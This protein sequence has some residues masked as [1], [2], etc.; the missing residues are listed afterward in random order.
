VTAS[1]ALG[2][3]GVVTRHF[4]P[5]LNAWIDGRRDPRRPDL[6]TYTMRHLLWSGL[7][8]LLG[9]IGSR[10]Q[11]T[12]ETA[13][14][15][16]LE[17][18]LGLSGSAEEEAAHPGTLNHL[19]IH[20]HPDELLELNAQL[21][22]RLF[23][24]RCLEP[25]RFEN[26][27]VVAVD[28]VE[29]RTYAEQHCSQCLHRQLAN[30]KPQFFHSILEAK[31]VLANGMALS[32][33]SVPIQNPAGEYEKQDCE[34]KA[35]PRL[36]EQLKRLYPRLPMCLVMD[37]MFATEPVFRLCREKGWEWIAVFK[38]G[39]AP[40]RWK[41]AIEACERHPRNRKQVHQEDG[42][43]QDFAWATDLCH[44][45]QIVHAIR[46][47]ET[48]PRGKTAHWAWVTSLRVNHRNV[49][50]IANQGGRLR[51]KIENEGFNVQKNGGIKL[52][53]DYGSQGYAWY[54]YYLLAQIA[55]LLLQLCWLGDAIRT[56]TGGACATMAKAFRTVRNFAARLRQA[57]CTATGP[58]PGSD[59]DPAA[60]QIRFSSA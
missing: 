41:E 17:A 23:R 19:M 30:G 52:K 31:L 47:A 60:I 11:H 46:C 8:M 38:E 48:H 50:V 29:I 3:L 39:R 24:M 1:D 45:Q 2:V 22:G 25:F 6:C 4:F 51:W 16:F 37:S 5:K 42:T 32:L 20:L 15:G 54:N 33:C 53:H 18:L 36:A 34:T 27:W 14:A 13:E 55:H 40:A 56:V 7:L 58:P 21:V 49:D 9:D 57:V 12:A 28:G 35:F 26:Q 43:D 10:L 44:G 59:V